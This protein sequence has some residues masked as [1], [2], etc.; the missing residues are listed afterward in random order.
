MKNLILQSIKDAFLILCLSLI[1]AGTLIGQWNLPSNFGQNIDATIAMGDGNIFFFKESGIAVFGESAPRSINS[2]SDWPSSWSAVTAALPWDAETAFLFS[3]SSYLVLNLNTQ[4]INGGDVWPG[5]PANWSEQIDAAVDWS[6]EEVYFF[7]GN[8]F[9]VYNK[10]TQTHSAAS[11]LSSWGL[12]ASWNKIEAALNAG[13][14][15]IYFFSGGQFIIYDQNAGTFTDP[16]FINEGGSVASSNSIPPPGARAVATDNTSTSIATNTVASPAQESP[17]S[18]MMRGDE[19]EEMETA[20]VDEDDPALLIRPTTP[21]P[22]EYRDDYKAF[23]SKLMDITWGAATSSSVRPLAAKNWIGT[24]VD[25]LYVDPMKVNKSKRAPKSA[26]IMTDSDEFAGNASE[27]IIPFGTKFE[28]IGQGDTQVGRQL[29]KTFGEFSTTFGGSIGGSVEVPMVASGSASASYKQM[30]NSKF[31][32][33]KVY[34]YKQAKNEL[35]KVAMYL[36]WID[37]HTNQK[38]RQKLDKSFRDFVG[39]LKVPSSM[40]SIEM[41]SK[42]GDKLPSSLNSVKASYK[43]MLKSFGTHITQSVTFGGRFISLYEINKSTYESARMD[44]AA[45]EAQAT[46]TIKGVTIGASA[47]FEYQNYRTEGKSTENFNESSYV[48]GGSG[49]T[50]ETWESKITDAPAPIAVELLPLHALLNEKYF[51]NDKD[52]KNKAEILKAVM[53]EYVCANM[54]LPVDVD[55]DGNS[56]F[57]ELAPLVYQYEVNIEHLKCKKIASGEPG[58][59]NEFFGKIDFFQDGKQTTVWDKDDDDTTP[60]SKGA[61]IPITIRDGYTMELAEGKQGT[62][63]VTANLWEEDTDYGLVGDDDNLGTKTKTVKL[64]EIGNEPKTIYLDFEHD[65]DEAE[66]KITITKKLKVSTY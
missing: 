64:H 55:L 25:I 66:I 10:S 37:N 48:T 57:K 14:G 44:Q 41:P 11:S 17:R 53:L 60:L 33:E 29:L 58:S 27:Y 63:K 4:S 56:F 20:S 54:N 8:E 12:P 22:D 36:D 31:G 9:V 28:S 59:E 47:S 26:I 1:G 61:M 16:S 2:I 15:S 45:F 34:G 62:F 46:G 7:Y 32:T 5:L 30:N 3:G 42:K 24:G 38:Y 50:F 39:R 49:T 6:S 65:G 43:S 40:P 19:G 23:T 51:P 13:E 52:I 18:V 21:F 35:Y